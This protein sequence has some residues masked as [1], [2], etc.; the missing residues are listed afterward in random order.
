VG[1]LAEGAGRDQVAGMLD[2]RRPA[3]VVA[4]E[5]D[6][7][8][9]PGERRRLEGLGRRATDRLLAQDVLAGGE[10]RPDHGQMGVVRR[11]DADGLDRRIGDHVRPV[12]RGPLEPEP[13]PG[14][15][16][17]ARVVVR[18]GDEPGVDPAVVEAVADE[19]VRAAVGLAHPAHAHHPDPDRPS[20]RG[21]PPPA[22]A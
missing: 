13:L 22:E 14:G 12:G 10:R 16:G 20:H 18:A 4:D 2:D 15:L 21:P 19:P 7:T 1:Q 5:R 9:A 8:G 6:E 3:V 17:P 11:R